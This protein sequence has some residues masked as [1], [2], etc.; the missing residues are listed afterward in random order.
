MSGLGFFDAEADFDAGDVGF[1]S[2]FA[3]DGFGAD[4]DILD[5]GV[6]DEAVA[7]DLG[8]VD[9]AADGVAPGFEVDFGVLSGVEDGH[10]GGDVVHGWFVADVDD[11]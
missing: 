6:G 1:P 8:G 10:D 7:G 3:F 4:V 2:V 9:G 5:D 11:V